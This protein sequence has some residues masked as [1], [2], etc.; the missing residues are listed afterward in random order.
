MRLY[1]PFLNRILNYWKEIIEKLDK[2]LFL[3]NLI[4]LKH[5][6]EFLKYLFVIEEENFG[7]ADG[8]L[9]VC[10]FRNLRNLEVNKKGKSL[11]GVKNKN[12]FHRGEVQD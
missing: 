11:A 6:A 3:I 8:I 10:S 5:L 12:L 9:K 7:V 4:Q 1:G 2:V